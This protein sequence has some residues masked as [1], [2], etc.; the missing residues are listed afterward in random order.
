MIS[1]VPADAGK[2]TVRLGKA[3]IVEGTCSWENPIYETVKLVRDPKTGQIKQ[4]IYY[5]AVASVSYRIANS[6]CTLTIFCWNIC[7]LLVDM[8]LSQGSSKSGFLG[9]VGL[10]FADLVE[11]TETLVVSLP[12][13]PLETGAILHVCPLSPLPNT[14]TQRHANSAPQM[15]KETENRLS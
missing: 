10:D 11:A 1:L 14:H 12:L 8:M 4:N 2:P 3:A 5:F 9:E 13:M 6:M 15:G 7:S